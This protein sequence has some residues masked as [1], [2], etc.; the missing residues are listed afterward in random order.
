MASVAGF[1]KDV[2]RHDEA[3]DSYDSIACE[4]NRNEMTGTRASQKLFDDDYLNEKL[5]RS[6]AKMFRDEFK[7]ASIFTSSIGNSSIEIELPLHGRCGTINER[8]QSMG[9]DTN[10][11]ATRNL[12]KNPDV[13]NR[14]AMETTEVA[15]EKMGLFKRFHHTY[16]QYG[17]VLVAVHCATST[18]WAGIFYY[19]AMSG[20]DIEPAL[21]WIGASETI[22]H[23]YTMPGVGSAAV[24][25]LFYK[26]A[27]PLRYP[28]TIACTHWAVKLLRERGYM[29]PVAR[30]NSIRSLVSEGRSSA[31]A[32]MERY[33]DRMEGFTEEMSERKVMKGQPKRF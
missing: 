24:A 17:K 6:D 9:S 4:V 22:V 30:E 10:L 14:D 29:P 21:R 20:V 25:Y 13:V 26:L 3:F 11:R 7:S 33:Q 28:V 19:A 32:R 5:I 18:V 16:K 12:D 8:E 27:T 15:T 1:R 23:F 31:R 2:S